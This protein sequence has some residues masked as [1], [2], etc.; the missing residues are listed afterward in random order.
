MK[1]GCWWKN[2]FNILEIDAD[3]SSQDSCSARAQIRNSLLAYNKSEPPTAVHNIH[4]ALAAAIFNRIMFIPYITHSTKRKTWIS[5]LKE[6]RKKFEQMMKVFSS[7]L[8]SYDV[9]FCCW[10]PIC[11]TWK[12]SVLFLGEIKWIQTKTSTIKGFF[13][14]KLTFEKEEIL[15]TFYTCFHLAYS[16]GNRSKILFQNEH[17]HITYQHKRMPNLPSPRREISWTHFHH[18]IYSTRNEKKIALKFLKGFLLM[19]THQNAARENFIK[20]LAYKNVKWF[21]RF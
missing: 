5:W 1:N 10:R 15:L 17:T 12:F 3:S 9:Y 7:T 8:L 16:S 13:Q 19:I 20:S 6:E 4:T 21:N 18:Q 2:E 11:C 14:A